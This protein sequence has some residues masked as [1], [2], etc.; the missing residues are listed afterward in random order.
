MSNPKQHKKIKI[1]VSDLLLG[2]LDPRIK[3]QEVG[4]K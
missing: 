2:V 1:V 4:N 3:V